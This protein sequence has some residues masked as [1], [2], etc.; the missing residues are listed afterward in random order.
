MIECNKTNNIKDLEGIG[1][2]A[3]RFIS[4]LYRSHWNHLIADKNNFSFRCKVKA[5]FN[6]QINRN[7]TPKKDKETD[8]PASVSVLSC[9]NQCLLETIWTWAK[10]M[11]MTIS[12]TEVVSVSA[13]YSR[14]HNLISFSLLSHAVWLLCFMDYLWFHHVF[15]YI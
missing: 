3:W 6:P 12:C 1:K 14:C 7:I 4:A 8:K 11:M 10:G 9:Y 15:L 5:Q 2:A 13:S